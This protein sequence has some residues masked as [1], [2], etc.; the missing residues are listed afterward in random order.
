MITKNK[1]L[2]S[3]ILMQQ[4]EVELFKTELVKYMKTPDK[5]IGLTK[6]VNFIR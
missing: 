4:T 5:V 6:F 2:L 1:L 3:F